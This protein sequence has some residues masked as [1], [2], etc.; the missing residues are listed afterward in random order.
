MM[1]LESAQSLRA[2]LSP[3]ADAGLPEDEQML[4]SP[5]RGGQPGVTLTEQGQHAKDP[6]WKDSIK[7]KAKKHKNN[8]LFP[9][10]KKK[11]EDCHLFSGESKSQLSC[12]KGVM[13]KAIAE[14]TAV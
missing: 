6:F 10:V 14:I 13:T 2:G 4:L 5:G 7:K 11:K 3:K 12:W 9:V 8:L 1:S